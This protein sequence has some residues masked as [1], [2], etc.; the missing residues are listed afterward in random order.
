MS[1]NI[2]LLGATYPD[3]PAVTLPQAGGGTAD[4]I[5]AEEITAALSGAKVLKSAGPAGVLTFDDA[6]AGAMALKVNVEAVQAGSGDPSPSN[7]RPITGWTGAKVS[8][9]GKN[10]FDASKSTEGKGMNASGN[11]TDNSS[12][13]VSDFMPVNESNLFL[14][15]TKDDS[16][17]R[18]YRVHGYNENGIWVKQIAVY[19]LTDAG[20]YNYSEDVESGIKQ[21]RISYPLAT[22]QMIVSDG[23]DYPIT[24]PSGAGTVGRGTLAVN[25]DGT[26]TLTVGWK[27]VKLNESLWQTVTGNTVRK[28]N[29]SFGDRK[30]G[31][32]YN[33]ICSAFTA[34][35][36]L[37]LYCRW[38]S[39]TGPYLG[40]AGTDASELTPEQLN[41]M[42]LAGEIEI[43]YEL[44]TPEVYALTPGQVLALAGLNNVWSDCGETEA[45]YPADVAELI[46]RHLS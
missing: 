7:P 19:E 16:Q 38:N 22:S 35:N 33:V 2:S 39:T 36:T 46:R 8:V 6:A 34:D 40:L 28:Y 12:F 13:A 20:S 31:N 18:R 14:S 45:E 9:T 32:N 24:F 41:T 26:G 1:K 23:N 5:E 10:L 21:I 3:V 11:I 43:I 27:Y 44:D 15:F 25:E 17:F 4:F 42:S 30:F 37:S 29:K